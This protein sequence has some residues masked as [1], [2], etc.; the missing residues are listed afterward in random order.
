MTPPTSNDV[1]R[2]PQCGTQYAPAV[3]FCPRDGTALRA[4]AG[5]GLVG[6]VL[7]ERYRVVRVLGEGGMGRV[8]L[9]EHV[10]MGRQCAIKVMNPTLANDDAA[11]GRFNREAANASRISHPHVAAIYDFGETPDGLVYLAMEYVDGEPLTALLERHGALPLARAVE[12]AR[13]VASALDAAHELGI[14]HRDLKPDNIMIARDRNDADVA[15]VVDFGIAKARDGEGAQ[16][17]TRTGMVVGTPEYMSPEQLAGDEVDA[18]SDVYA[19]GLVTY[20]MLTGTLPFAG[21]TAQE[22]MLARLT[23]PPRTLAQVRPDVTWPEGVQAALD[24]ALSRTPGARFARAGEFADALIAAHT[25]EAAEVTSAAAASAPATR[26][27]ATGANAAR[28]NTIAAHAAAAHAAPAH[29]GPARRGRLV[30]FAVAVAVIGLA[31]WVAR[32]RGSRDGAAPHA[33]ARDSATLLAEGAQPGNGETVTDSAAGARESAARA[34]SSVVQTS[35]AAQRGGTDAR[36]AEGD[37]PASVPPAATAPVRQ[38]TQQRTSGGERAGTRLDGAAANGPQAQPQA[39]GVE[40]PGG[41]IRT[42][43]EGGRDEARR[44]RARVQDAARRI[45]DGVAAGHPQQ[46]SIALRE[47]E[48][49]LPHLPGAADSAQAFLHISEA[50]IARGNRAEGCRILT[51]LKD[52]PGLTLRTARSNYETFCTHQP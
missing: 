32:V 35:D 15:K 30:G 41:G 4:V 34:P 36:N 48:A 39:A 12:I 37:Q 7:A 11:L 13:Q 20:H 10:K 17:V 33:S 2:C 24:R 43:G 1:K 9:A 31:V 44:A 45:R 16:R 42:V 19:L 40:P 46:L 21:T 6:D 51:R 8:Y 5:A 50:L 49:A 25:P 26:A 38:A 52:I 29:A 23:Q 47:L 28:A 14:I 3:M 18:R 22:T 27:H